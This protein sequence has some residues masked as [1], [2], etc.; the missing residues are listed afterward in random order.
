MTFYSLNILILLALLT[1]GC[2]T[3]PESFNPTNAGG[4]LD[5]AAIHCLDWA[6]Y[7]K[8]HVNEVG[9]GVYKTSTGYACGVLT[10]GNSTGVT[11]LAPKGWI[12]II[13]THPRGMSNVS[14]QDMYNVRDDLRPSYVRSS[15]GAVFVYEC[16]E[17]KQ[18]K[19]HCAGR[20]VR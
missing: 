14:K 3:I 15:G 4:T 19:P 16:K 11:I 6:W 17:S 2:S 18:G 12:A 20:R 8:D 1:L 13:H 7:E 9:G 5:E 10:V